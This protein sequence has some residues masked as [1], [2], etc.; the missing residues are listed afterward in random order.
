[1]LDRRGPLPLY[2]QLK[3]SLLREIHDNGLGPGN[4][5]PSE[6]QIESRYGVSRTT[7]RQALNEL[8]VEGV[9]ERTQGKGTFVASP[10]ITHLP[11]LTS[12]TENMLS[13]GYEPSR[14][15]LVSMVA[16]PPEDIAYRLQLAAR[17]RCRF[18][19]RLL[20]ADQEIVGLAE[21]WLPLDI[22]GSREEL[23]DASR[24]EQ[25]SLYDLLQGPDIKLDL[26]RGVEKVYPAV[27][28]NQYAAF[29]ECSPESPVLVVDRLTY[30]SEQRPVEATH[31]V[32][33]GSR[34]EYSVEM[35][36]PDLLR[37]NDAHQAPE[38]Y[39]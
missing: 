27:A 18:L 15:V 9:I 16:D 23:F 2:F 12:F 36:R 10:N 7:I 3:H 19:R 39:Q 13:Q 20:L 29:L 24:L 33:D 14:R 38:M 25:G 30:T 8:A 37:R 1:M 32:F 21:T 26:H 34:Y 31:M 28:S 6:A 4:R 22:L 17:R 35:F 5:L 11:L